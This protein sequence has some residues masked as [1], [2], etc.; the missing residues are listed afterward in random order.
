MTKY[1]ALLEEIAALRKR[2]DATKSESTLQALDRRLE[3]SKKAFDK[4][5]YEQRA[6][7]RLVDASPNVST[8]RAVELAL[9]K[10]R[11]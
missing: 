9:A 1:R 7:R 8:V 6:V 3:A 11:P 10:P 4:L 5:F 2:L